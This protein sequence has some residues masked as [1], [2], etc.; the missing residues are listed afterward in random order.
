MFAL[1]TD[2]SQ[3]AFELLSRT[4]VVE[5]AADERRDNAGLDGVEL[6]LTSARR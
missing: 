6:R 5:V 2:R 1:F 4:R 3:R